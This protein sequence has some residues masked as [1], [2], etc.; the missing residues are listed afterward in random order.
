MY[1]IIASAIND[2]E[3]IGIIRSDAVIPDGLEVFYFEVLIET[4]GDDGNVAIGIYPAEQKLQGL[5][6]WF[7]GSY[8]YH[9]D[10]GSKF[11]YLSS[12]DEENDGRSFFFICIRCCFKRFISMIC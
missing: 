6:G 9:G 8:G 3:R 2:D 11:R 10:D 5:P 1:L 7:N 4:E 12:T